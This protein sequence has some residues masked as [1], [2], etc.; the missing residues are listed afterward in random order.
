MT[1][2]TR[3]AN[4]NPP[5]FGVKTVVWDGKDVSGTTVADGT[6]KIFVESSWNNPS[7]PANQHST[8]INFIFEKSAEA[9]HA[10]PA[11]DTYFSDITLDW[12]PEAVSIQTQTLNQYI[13]VYPNPSNGLVQIN[14]EKP[15]SVSRILVENMNGQVVSQE[16]L[17]E[18][19]S[20]VHSMNLQQLSAGIYFIE[21]LS[22]DNSINYKSKI[23]I[24]K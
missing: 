17:N 15:N 13:S 1:G 18:I 9:T 8:I 22:T 19:I 12:V 3:T 23:I 21:V 24:N 11:G 20:G 16:Y 4:T 7:P 10:T 14:F 6:Y 5:A 2:A